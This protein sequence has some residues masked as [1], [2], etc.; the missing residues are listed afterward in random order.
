M[1]RR[2]FLSLM[3]SVLLLTAAFV[4][5][6]GAAQAAGSEISVYVD[7]EKL[8]FDQP[9]VAQNGRVLVPLRAIFEALGAEVEWLPEDQAVAAQKG[10]TL[11]VM[12]LG[13]NRFAKSV[14]GGDSVV[15]D[16]DVPPIALN[17]RTLVPVR[18]VSESFD[19]NV[20]W[21]GSSQTVTVSSEK[22]IDGSNAA[23]N[24]YI[25]N[26]VLYYSFIYQPYIY[27]YDGA[28]TRTYASGGAPLGIVVNRNQI[29]YIN[30]DNQTVNAINMADG[31]RKTV[32][33]KLSQVSDFSI[34]GD[35]MVIIGFEGETQRV[36]KLDLTSGASQVL[37]TRP[38]VSGL[39][40]EDG[41]DFALWK[42]YLFVVEGISPLLSGE[43]SCKILMIDTNTGIS[44]EICNIKGTV[45]QL[46][47]KDSSYTHRYV[48]A[49]AKFDQ[50]NAYFG[51]KFSRN[52][53]TSNYYGA[54]YFT[55][56]YQISLD[57]GAVSEITESQ[58]NSA[59]DLSAVRTGEWTYGS[60]GSRVYGTN[61]NTG[62]TETL[63][64]GENYYYITNDGQWVAVLKAKSAGAGTPT[65]TKGYQY[66]EMYVMDGDGNNLR[67]INSYTNSS[68]TSSPVGEMD[69]NG[70][71]QESCAVCG[72]SGMVTCPYCRGT[73]QG[74]SI[75]IMGM[76]TPQG[77]T[78][79]G[80]TGRRLCSGCG[81]SGVKN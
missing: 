62:I 42:Q 29:Y 41:S 13:N 61:I 79:C 22:W 67:T 55:E 38:D 33:A 78:Y 35:K 6:G 59:A 70:L 69:V 39:I 5:A 60:D 24:G 51:I 12:Q 73:G 9:P 58:F 76:D 56:Y 49:G 32:F 8:T 34:C 63:L 28:A 2:R 7:G 26:G 40:A 15:Y 72:G 77:C 14:G 31:Q 50:E 30:R 46:G 18:A 68:N 48:E 54:E 16:L 27:A 81:G 47:L 45:T 10:D 64:S 66:A 57:S 11:V 75:S 74:Q 20:E 4:P 44:K 37:Y 3:L 65:A 52:E 80:S 21:D 25:H 23:T 1:K 19:C 36:Y 71:P 43:S 17:G 53:D